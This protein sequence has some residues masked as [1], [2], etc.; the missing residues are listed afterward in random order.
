MRRGSLHIR[1]L[2]PIC[3]TISWTDIV[4]CYLLQIKEDQKR[5]W[6][7]EEEE[8]EEKEEEEEESTC[9]PGLRT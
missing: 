4:I 7:P 3:R 1:V 2:F 9:N 8:E 5:L 6:R